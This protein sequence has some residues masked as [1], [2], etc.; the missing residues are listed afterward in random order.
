VNTIIPSTI[1]R[2]FF[3]LLLFRNTMIE[4][5]IPNNRIPKLFNEKS[6]VISKKNVKYLN[7][8]T[9]KSNLQFTGH[10]SSAL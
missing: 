7:L 5:E 2:I 3:S 10:Y 4:I 9:Q 6:N 8:I 1:F